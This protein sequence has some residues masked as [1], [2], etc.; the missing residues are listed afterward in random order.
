MTDAPRHLGKVVCVAQ[1]R[2]TSSRLPGKILMTAAG[3][4][5]LQWHLERLQA[6][7]RVDQV[8]LATTSNLSDDPVAELAEK[9]GVFVFRGSEHDVLGR[10]AGCAAACGADTVI[11][12]TAD[13]PLIDPALID[14]LADAFAATPTIDYCSIDVGRFPRGLD[15][16]I[17]AYSSL[18]QAASEA[19]EP[20][21]REHVTPFIY[22]RPDRFRLGA[23]LGPPPGAP[24]PLA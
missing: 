3:K 16:E 13:C 6:A 1:A 12:V 22:R 18:A 2:M 11:R 5:L 23:P 21:E 19:Q 7:K 20:F 17:F 24:P 10:F 9:L 4:P 15:A 8:A 14:D